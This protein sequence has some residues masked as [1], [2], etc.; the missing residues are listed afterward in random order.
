MSKVYFTKEI[1]SESLIRIFE[2]LNVELK[3]KVGVKISTGEEGSKGYL[4]PE[5]IKGLVQKVNGTI[6]ECN[7]AYI[8]QRQTTLDHLKVI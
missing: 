7:T 2:K 4:K 3:G 5:L 6:V 1:S 8:G